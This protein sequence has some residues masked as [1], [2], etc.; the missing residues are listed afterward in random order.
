MATH[1][2][3]LA[4]DRGAW[5]ATAHSIAKSQTRL[6]QLSL[7]DVWYGFNALINGKEESRNR[8][9]IDVRFTE[10]IISTFNY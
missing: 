9:I 8:L 3:I 5:R 6:K 10:N 4:T 7:C 1:S 2:S